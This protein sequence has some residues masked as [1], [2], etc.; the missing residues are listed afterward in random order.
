MSVQKKSRLN[1][2][3]DSSLNELNLQTIN[4]LDPDDGLDNEPEIARAAW[5]SKLQYLLTI[6]GYA[7]GLGNIW[8]FPYL[9]QQNGGGAFLIPYFL[10]LFLEGIP[11]FYLEL[12]IGQRIRK[13]SI[14]VWNEISPILGGLGITACIVSFIIGL[15][16]NVIIA[17]CLYYIFMS[18][19]RTL[20]WAYCPTYISYIP[21]PNISVQHV[22]PVTP[23]TLSFLTSNLNKLEDKLFLYNPAD[24]INRNN[25]SLSTFAPGDSTILNTTLYSMILMSIKH[26]EYNQSNVNLTDHKNLLPNLNGLNI[27]NSSYLINTNNWDLK[28]ATSPLVTDYL[29]SIIDDKSSSNLS[30]SNLT[31]VNR[32]TILNLNDIKLSQLLDSKQ[33]TLILVNPKSNINVSSYPMIPVKKPVPE[34]QKSSSTQYFWY[35][36]TLDVSSGI[37]TVT[38][39]N[40]RIMLCLAL[41]WFTVFICIMKGIKS[42]GK[43]AYFTATFPY[44]VLIIIFGRSITLKGAGLGLRHMFYPRTDKLLDPQVWLDAATQIFYSLGLGFGSIIAFSSYNPPRNNCK[45]DAILVSCINCSTS[46]FACIVIFSVLGFK[47]LNNY[48]TCIKLNH[49]AIYGYYK[50]SINISFIESE[51]NTFV[52][53]F[54]GNNSVLDL[55]RCNLQDN[56]NQAAEGTGLAFI[57]FTQ[58]I[59]EF[60]GSPFW[61]IIFFSMLITLGLGTMFGIMEGLITSIHD[62]HLFPWLR[63]EYLSAILCTISFLT[64]LIFV[65]SSGEYWVKLFDTFAGTLTL[66][67]VAFFEIIAVIY[68]YGHKKFSRDLEF[69]TGTY[70]GWYWQITWRYVSPIL[71]AG[72]LLASTIK[73]IL[74]R[75]QY[76]SYDSA[77]ALLV[78]TPYPTWVLGV[79]ALL[80]LIG[81]F[82]IPFVAFLRYFRI[83]KFET[84]IPTNVKRFHTS[85]STAKILSSTS[86][87]NKLDEIE[88]I[89]PYLETIKEIP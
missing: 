29:N 76:N 87:L 26:L 60:P 5:G 71:M 32:D 56:L 22:D 21:D 85:E 39:F 37:D 75:P 18:F 68:I 19:R 62:L 84:D 55:E 64:G 41:S 81:T 44:A 43:A 33:N 14:G 50:G 69:M 65:L 54:S 73:W 36:N 3:K 17:W 2:S 23:L 42:S 34:C 58:A 74:E 10:M 61:S 25:Y 1:S 46:I 77:K 24:M 8:R 67:I 72:I 59:L 66:V 79:V 16:Y 88:P 57:V 82:P 83:M 47:A 51:Y 28:I 15:Y 7:V 12:G 86:T 45:K 35:R 38:S 63:K 89:K 31:R 4:W 30:F 80:I 11:L 9:C 13:G 70:P 20:P 48:E 49:E 27:G 78:K 40:W 6:V 52:K 53:K